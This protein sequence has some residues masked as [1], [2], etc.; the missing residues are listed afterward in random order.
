MCNILFVYARF[1][2]VTVVDITKV[3]YF[4]PMFM[5]FGWEG[6]NV[7]LCSC[8]FGMHMFISSSKW[9]GWEGGNVQLC[10]CDFGMHMFI[11]SSMWFGWEGGNV[12]LCS[13]DFGVHMF[14]CS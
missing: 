3:I 6:G 13:C 2:E 9:F 5:W 12:Q 14:I 7:Q 8:D 11:S 4:C 10:S 1:I